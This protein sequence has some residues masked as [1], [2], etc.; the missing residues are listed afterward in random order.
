MEKHEGMDLAEDDFSY[1]QAVFYLGEGYVVKTVVTNRAYYFLKKGEKVIM[2]SEGFK[3]KLDMSEFS[4]LYKE[5][6][7]SLVEGD[8][9]TVDEKKDEEYYS[10][11]NET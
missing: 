2:V 3:A 6:L 9:P 11:R 8:E 7:F 10:W 1:E 4:S 5:A